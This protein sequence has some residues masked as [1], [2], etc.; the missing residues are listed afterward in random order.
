[1]LILQMLD[2]GLPILSRSVTK[3]ITECQHESW[4][5]KNENGQYTRNWLEIYNIYIAYKGI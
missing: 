3:Y 2:M 5:A 1:M 4:W